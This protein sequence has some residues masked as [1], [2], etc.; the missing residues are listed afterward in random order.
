MM[1][2]FLRSLRLAAVTKC[3]SVVRKCF[4]TVQWDLA[5][6]AWTWLGAPSKLVSLLRC[7][8]ADQRRWLAVRGHFAAAPVVPSRGILQGCPASVGLLNALMLLWARSVKMATPSI[9]QSIFLDDR[10][11]WA[12]GRT[13]PDTLRDALRTA[14]A[15]DRAIGLSVHPDKLA[16]WATRA[17]ARRTLSAE[18]DLFGPLVSSFKLLGVNYR[19]ST[20][21]GA[22][23]A[24]PLTKVIQARCRRIALAARMLY[25]RRHLL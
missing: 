12:T 25:M 9:R 18:A 1:L 3:L 11:L 24:A 23:D 13:G 6:Q 14:A 8:Y 16:C 7:F 5:L 2:C 17:A 22:V 15:T 20:S 10:A 19:L 4:D 21:A